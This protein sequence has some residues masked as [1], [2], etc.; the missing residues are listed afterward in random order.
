M[1]L[2]PHPQSPPSPAQAID[3]VCARLGDGRLSLVF[4]VRGEVERIRWPAAK[5][6]ERSDGLWQSTCFEAF[7]RSSGS[8]AYVEL[9]LSPSGDWAAYGFDSCR[10][11]ISEAPVPP[12]ASK[13]V[14]VAPDCGVVA[15]FDL[16]ASPDLPGNSLWQ[17]GLSAVIE[18]DDGSLSHWALVHPREVPDFHHPDC[19]VVEL[20]PAGDP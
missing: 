16:S 14:K 20:P 9:N 7:V 8:Q 11:G 12:P 3:A 2:R 13:V 17:L 15:S 18:A 5:P 10:S 4:T 1:E 6:P 19:F